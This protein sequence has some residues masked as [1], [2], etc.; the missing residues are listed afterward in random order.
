MCVLDASTACT[1]DGVAVLAESV[2]AAPPAPPRSDVVSTVQGAAVQR[3]A[4]VP[5]FRPAA[6]PAQGQ[7]QGHCD[8]DIAAWQDR[9]A[10]SRPIPPGTHEWPGRLCQLVRL[11]HAGNGAKASVRDAALTRTRHVVL[12]C[13]AGEAGRTAGD[14]ARRYRVAQH[15]IIRADLL[16]R[17]FLE[18]D[19]AGTLHGDA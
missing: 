7:A 4:P 5:G 2:N 3:A 12:F 13:L 6:P 17:Q 9:W 10:V 1:P 18:D 8:P 14:P 11:R 16:V 15:P 19:T